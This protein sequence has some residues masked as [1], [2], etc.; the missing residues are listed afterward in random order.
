MTLL[1]QKID[2][3]F[4]IERSVLPVEEKNTIYLLPVF[5]TENPGIKPRNTNVVLKGRHS[6]LQR[7]MHGGQFHRT[8]IPHTFFV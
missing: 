2:M 4:S 7:W 8:Y 5:V 1:P 6:L 3:W